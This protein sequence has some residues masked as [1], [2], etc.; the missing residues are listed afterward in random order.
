MWQSL[1]PRL[2]NPNSRMSIVVERH[3]RLSFIGNWLYEFTEVENK[4]GRRLL[5]RVWRAAL[6]A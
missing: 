4:L 3:R 6:S 5:G 1:P 2:L